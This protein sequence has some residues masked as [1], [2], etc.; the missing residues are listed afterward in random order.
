MSVKKNDDIYFYRTVEIATLFHDIG[1]FKFRA[2]KSDKKK[3]HELYSADFISNINLPEGIDKE[4]VINL[5]KL[6]HDGSKIIKG[7]NE[8]RFSD[9]I[10]SEM[11]REGEEETDPMKPLQPIFQT[12][13]LR[14]TEADQVSKRYTINEK[15]VYYP[16]PLNAKV[17]EESIFPYE[18]QKVKKEFLSYSSPSWEEFEEKMRLI[19]ENLPFST[20]IEIVN[21]LLLVYTSNIASAAY[22]TKPYISLYNHLVATAAIARCMV[23]YN[24]VIP[25]GKQKFGGEEE[26]RY[27]IISGDISGI[28]SFIFKM[29]FP[30][31]A[32]KN[33]ASRLR[34]K[35]FYLELLSNAI[36]N[37]I[38]YKFN[39]GVTNIVSFA[40]GN[41][42][43][44]APNTPEVKE[45]L[46]EVKQKIENYL[47][48]QFGLDLGLTLVWTE[49]SKKELSDY[50]LLEEKVSKDIELAK[51][52]KKSIVLFENENNVITDKTLEFFEKKEAPI[53]KKKCVV[54]ESLVELSIK[55]SLCTNC[56]N[57]EKIGKKLP[58]TKA[59]ILTRKKIDKNIENNE[60][61]IS[62]LDYKFI[63]AEKNV[64][65]LIQQIN[66]PSILVYYS[67][68]SDLTNNQNISNVGLRFLN[69]QISMPKHDEKLI[70]FDYLAEASHGIKR[71]GILKADVDNLGTIFK[72]GLS[73]KKEQNELKEK[74]T[75]SK[76]RD[77]SMR[78]ELF[79]GYYT[80]V[81]AQRPQFRLWIKT[82]SK[83]IDYFE[84]VIAS[85]EETSS[86]EI[87]FYRHNS[88]KDKNNEVFS[89]KEC[90]KKSN[91]TSAIY[92]LFSGG[93]DFIFIG[94]W[95]MI[96]DFAVEVNKEFHK[97]ISNNPWITISAGIELAQSNY[98]IS[99]A[100]INAEHSLEESKSFLKYKNNKISLKNSVTLFGETLLWEKNPEVYYTHRE[101]TLGD[102][103]YLISCAKKIAEEEKSSESLSRSFIYNLLKMWELTF[104]GMSKEDI[105]QQRTTKIEFYPLLAYNIAKRYN[106]EDKDDKTKIKMKKEKFDF[107]K[108]ILPWMKVPATWA[109]YRNKK[110]R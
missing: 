16:L 42:K 17:I 22:R 108:K 88:L 41:F 4:Q 38:L 32:R 85:S 15:Q 55:E 77:L 64:E 91:Y 14:D 86:T 67:N 44:I 19:P 23:E 106:K 54:C 60:L 73:S 100:L 9:R 110:R 80:T 94:P 98:P 81:I 89:C 82:C 74:K 87:T 76:L 51:Y 36:V 63:F 69:F 45:K 2:I 66:D 40:A 39:L 28:Q 35:S 104:I 47:F 65:N 34:G 43:I 27:L 79:F 84:E 83:H 12:L 10:S 71:L 13:N 1:K 58:K 95:D 48:S 92:G 29:R 90:N 21:S 53:N 109:L 68:F 61:V 31:Q 26:P 103:Q 24:T 56:Q 70:S 11:D 78:L 107:F 33:S 37:E 57:H 30:A 72:A 20:W 50:S 99:R 52:R 6:H 96:I 97:Y 75:L 18:E 25:E 5:V 8:L 3:K 101:G 62:I 49:I 46:Y 105:Q 7:L 59:I 93:D 102:F